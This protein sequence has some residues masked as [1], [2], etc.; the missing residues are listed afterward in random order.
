MNPM[1]SSDNR[2]EGRTSPTERA[3]RYREAVLLF[4]AIRDLPL[5]EARAKIAL[6]GSEAVRRDVLSMLDADRSGTERIRTIVDVSGV[7][8]ESQAAP[9]IPAAIGDYKV[10]GLLG[11]GGGGVV[12]KGVCPKTGRDVAIKVLGIGAW[13]SRALGRFRQEIKLLGHLSHPGI[14][15]ILDAGTDRSGVSPH[16]YFVMEFVDGRGL[17]EW[18]RERPRSAREVVLLFA[19]LLEAVAFSHAR[20]ITH[21]DLK[22]SNILVTPDGHP[23]ILDF[24]VATVARDADP[25]LDPLRTLT[26][27]LQLGRTSELRGDTRG[28]PGTADG[29]V[30]GTL[31]YMSPEQ[32]SGTQLVDARSDLYSIGVML[33]EA[34]CGKLPYELGTRSLTD[35]ATVIRS[36]IPTSIGRVDRGLRGDLE[37]IVSRL[38]EKRPVDRYQ[39]AQELVEDLERYLRGQRAQ[40][41]RIPIATRML[42]FARRY[43]AYI[44]S[45]AVLAAVAG[46]SLA[47]SVYL[48]AAERIEREQQAIAQIDAMRKDLSGAAFMVARGQVGNSRTFL[49]SVAEPQ[50]NWAWHAM[51]RFLNAGS[52]VSYV[53]YGAYQLDVRGERVFVR[54]GGDGTLPAVF[55]L[56][57]GTRWSLGNVSS[58]IA[59]LAVS[60]DGSRFALGYAPEGWMSV[61]AVADGSVIDVINTPLESIDALAWSDD[62]SL[63]VCADR[64]GELAVLDLASGNTRRTRVDWRVPSNGRVFLAAVDGLVMAA[65]EGA[66]AIVA[67]SAFDASAG[68]ARQISL[69]GALAS[70]MVAARIDGVPC[71]AVGTTRGSI[72]VLDAAAGTIARS[73]EF[74]SSPIVA[75]GLEPRRGLVVAVTG[76][77]EDARR[78]TLSA[79][80]LS[81]GALVGCVGLRSSPMSLAFS[82]DGER[83]FVGLSSG[84]L[85]RYDVAR[86]LLL[87]SIGGPSFRVERMAFAGR[88]RMVVSTADGVYTWNWADEPQASRARPER[89][90]LASEAVAKRPFAALTIAA[91]GAAR[92]AEL[93]L[94]AIDR[95]SGSVRFYAGSG[96]EIGRADIDAPMPMGAALSITATDRGFMI[97]AGTRILHYAVRRDGDSVRADLLGASDLPMP[98]RGVASTPDGRVAVATMCGDDG[99]SPTLVGLSMGA[100]GGPELEWTR[101]LA[102]KSEADALRAALAPDGS[103]AMTIVGS[104]ELAV[105]EM[106]DAQNIFVVRDFAPWNID[107]DARDLC[108]S[109]DGSAMAVLFA[110]GTVRLIEATPK[111]QLDPK[112]QEG[113]P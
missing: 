19:E 14:A 56:R 7:I 75:T 105:Y 77:A 44:A 104:N 74:A 34:L 12:L 23:K 17:A 43:P 62:G 82:Q 113:A 86:D 84:E 41:R 16:P 30:V 8:S 60:P 68:E 90:P 106:R 96:N 54:E 39:T 40:M 100:T 102:E 37:I 92:P 6:H 47:Y 15:Q 72:L 103:C 48:L 85:M 91:A 20:G 101:V 24:G 61:Q 99:S 49:A 53:F 64:R 38:L 1:D 73:I 83:L 33:Y 18:R 109:P 3:A 94:A 10:T 110:D 9:E 93:V 46:G 70:S 55:D 58:A 26:M 32:I 111:P 35:A 31:P 95:E 36:E 29:S 65:H 108:M 22:P 71:I 25:S 59:P 63:L 13:S 79:W 89:W 98:V 21:R 112:S 57:D 107:R 42:R 27:M 69:A 45:F 5:E 52:L 80:D 50:R 78:G 66:D 4:D 67:W 76:V 88:G 11:Q 2:P 87:P 51:D 28:Q 97:G 81:T